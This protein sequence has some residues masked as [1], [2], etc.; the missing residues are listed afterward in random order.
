MPGRL[1]AAEYAKNH[2]RPSARGCCTNAYL[3]TSISRS[4]LLEVWRAEPFKKHANRVVLFVSGIRRWR[5]S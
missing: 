4:I 1:K 3:R 2:L 5:L